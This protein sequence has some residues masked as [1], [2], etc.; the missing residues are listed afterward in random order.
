M[1]YPILKSKENEFLALK[2]ISATSK[3]EISPVFEILPETTDNT[4]AKLLEFWSFD[5]N[6]VLIDASLYKTEDT[7]YGEI[8]LLLHELV[9][10]DVNPVPVI[11]FNSPED[12]LEEVEKF[13]AENDTKICIR[14]RRKLLRASTLT[15]TINELTQRFDLSSNQIILLFDLEFVTDNDFESKTDILIACLDELDTFNDYDDVVISSGSFPS[16]LGGV[17]ADTRELLSRFEWQIWNRILEETDKG[18]VSYGDYGIKHPV[19][20]DTVR[21]FEPSSSI[22]YTTVDNYLIYRGVKPSRHVKA[23]GQ[24]HDKCRLLVRDSLY[25]GS[26]FSW[27]DNEIYACSLRDT[28]PG[29]AGTWVKIGHNHHFAKI[30]SLL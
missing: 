7:D 18:E 28:N 22:K 2:E 10:G 30:L 8:S 13:L 19:Y 23:G 16:N 14:I 4:L 12:Y 29:N 21:K 11:E 27:A 26:G 24:Y 5:S 9:D 6:Q 20:D 3:I 15:A 25:D 1:Y 17:A